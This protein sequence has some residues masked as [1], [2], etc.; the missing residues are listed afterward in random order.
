[1]KKLNLLLLLTFIVSFSY[2][3]SPSRNSLFIPDI[4]GYVTLKCDLHMHTV[5]S[6]GLV[7]PDV[8]IEEAFTEGLDAIAITDH[9]EYSPHKTDVPVNH[10]RPYE[11]ASRYAQMAGIILIKG[12]E[13]TRKM[14]PGHLNALF[15]EEPDSLVK[16]SY[17][18][19]LLAA[20]AQ[21]AVIF[22]NHPGWAPQAPDGIKWYD[23]HTALVDQ[24][25]ID[26]IEIVNTNEYYPEAFSWCV[27]QDLA[28]LGNSDI[29]GTLD[30]FYRMHGVTHRPMTIV[31]AKDRS[32]EGIKEAILS[33]RSIVWFGDQVIGKEIFIAELVKASLEFHEA[34][35][36]AGETEFRKLTNKSCLGFVIT[37][38]GNDYT[39]E[40]YSEI[41]VRLKTTVEPELKIHNFITEKG[42]LALVL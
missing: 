11:I 5:F 41:I 15:I 32:Q 24:N 29:H 21:G 31:F 27:E 16:D 26:G 40:P 35:Y 1:M 6:D 39:L 30:G 22:W 33:K 37:A 8:R 20:K 38:D 10:S 17:E 3:Q 13:I 7:W 4:P 14:P 34:H 25:I 28:I 23:E 36:T 9:I 12:S 2:S 18:D 19:A 42:E